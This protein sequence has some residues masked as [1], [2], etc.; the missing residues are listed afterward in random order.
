MKEFMMIFRHTNSN[1][2]TPSAEEMQEGM[3]EWQNWIGGIA[4]QVKL[5]ST[6]QLGFEGKIL[7]ANCIVLDGPHISLKEMVGGNMIVKAG[8]LEEAVEMAKGCPIL[9]MGGNIEIRNIMQLNS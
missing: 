3:K 2:Y 5:V 7:K 6:H 1:N 9:G 4:A 8:S